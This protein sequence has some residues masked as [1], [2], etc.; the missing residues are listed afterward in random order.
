MEE[1]GV[2]QQVVVE[3]VLKVFVVVWC[4]LWLG[5]FEVFGLGY[6]CVVVVGVEVVLVFEDEVVFEYVCQF[7]GGGQFVVGEDVV[8]DLG[9]G[10]WC[11]LVYVDGVQQEEVFWCQQL[12]GGVEVGDVVF[13]V[14]MFE[15]VY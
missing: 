3:Y 9:V 1:V 12:V 5:G 10:V 11:V 15:Y 13:Q 7:C 14:D 4:Q 6:Q 8:F 2:V